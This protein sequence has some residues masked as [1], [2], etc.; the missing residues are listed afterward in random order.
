MTLSIRS[1][2]HLAL[3]NEIDTSVDTLTE[4]YPAGVGISSAVTA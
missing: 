4:E 3:L 2:C 1:A